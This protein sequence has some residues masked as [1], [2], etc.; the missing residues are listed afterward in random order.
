MQKCFA[1]FRYFKPI[2]LD[3]LI[4]VNSEERLI[5]LLILVLKFEKANTI[6]KEKDL[7]FLS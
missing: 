1:I 5:A 7:W 6:N 3:K 4:R 2:D